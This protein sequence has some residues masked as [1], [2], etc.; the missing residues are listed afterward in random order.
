MHIYYFTNKNNETEMGLQWAD[1]EIIIS[2][3]LLLIIEF[4]IVCVWCFNQAFCR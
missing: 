3:I 1:F 2:L 4:T